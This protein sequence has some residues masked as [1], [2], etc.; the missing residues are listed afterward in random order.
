MQANRK[1]HRTI[2]A[3]AWNLY[4]YTELKLNVWSLKRQKKNCWIE[5]LRRHRLPAR[6]LIGHWPC[7]KLLA[8]CVRVLEKSCVHMCML[9]L[10]ACVSECMCV[11]PWPMGRRLW[12]ACLLA[13]F[14]GLWIRELIILQLR[15]SEACSHTRTHP[16]T[17][18]FTHAC[19]HICRHIY[20]F[21]HGQSEDIYSTAHTQAHIHT[22]THTHTHTHR[23][24][25]GLKK[26]NWNEI[27][28]QL[29]TPAGKECFDYRNK[30]V[31]PA[32]FFLWYLFRHFS[33]G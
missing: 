5:S 13:A 9:E 23:Q 4:R 15:L 27:R 11:C 19:T 1:Q 33:S 31:R 8:K 17:Q 14:F 12:Q 22:H 7:H 21:T 20:T 30:T 32:D 18:A 28:Y 3:A 10:Q 25:Q 2:E 24:W 16:H 6:I 26:T 29:N